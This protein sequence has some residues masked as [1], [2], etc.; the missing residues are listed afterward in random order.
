MLW[1]CDCSRSEHPS[2]NRSTSQQPFPPRTETPKFRSTNTQ[3]P[4]RETVP[5]EGENGTFPAKRRSAGVLMK[6]HGISGPSWPEAGLPWLGMW[7]G[8]SPWGPAQT[9]TRHWHLAGSWQL[10]LR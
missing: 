5:K 9:G 10:R 8:F 4:G 7:D 3:V 2:W 6:C 1:G